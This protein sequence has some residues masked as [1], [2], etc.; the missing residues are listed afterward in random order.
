M[1]GKPFFKHDCDRCRFIGAAEYA[2]TI[3]DYYHCPGSLG[4]SLIARYGN[5]GPEYGSADVHTLRL[6]VNDEGLHN[7]GRRSYSQLAIVGLHLLDLN[8]RA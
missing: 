5:E 6:R 2:G 8:G 3:A 1:K 7:D 4:G